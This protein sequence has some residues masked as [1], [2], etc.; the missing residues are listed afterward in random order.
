MF[1][2]SHLRCFVAVADELHFGRAAAR[3]HMTQPPLSR[4]IQQLEHLLD[5]ELLN[6][7]SRS[8][9][10]TPAGRSFLTEARRLLNLAES[11]AL[12]ARRVASGTDGSI[13]VGFTASVSY[14]YLPHLL[15]AVRNRLKNIDLTLNEMVT[16]E[17]LGALTSGVLD[18]G[19]MRP[20]LDNEE[21]ESM[22]VVQERLVC[23][24]PI[25]HAF[26]RRRTVQLRDFDHELSIGY[27]PVE[28]RY[29]YDLSAA[30][31]LA[32]QAMPRYVQY[33]SQVHAILGLVQA[34]LGVALV[35][36]SARKLRFEGVVLRDVEMV[37]QQPVETCAVWK[38][39]NENPA[40]KGF[41]AIL[42]E[43]AKPN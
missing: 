23:A 18:V 34:G 43:M 7:S 11:A 35:P 41:L 37:R 13:A 17:Q 21:L 5:V 2:L 25:D 39:G 30:A 12:S 33:M 27:S 22:V 3:L 28:A 6:R 32:A 36:E 40:L 38:R 10:L 42:R 24:A 1:E 29:F 4:Q 14:S 16:Q 26:A 20:M 8:V 31:F 19:L 9:K 15:V